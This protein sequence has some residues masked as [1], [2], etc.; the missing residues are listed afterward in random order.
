M[1]DMRYLGI[2]PFNASITSLTDQF[3]ALKLSGSLWRHK[4]KLCQKSDR[5]IIYTFLEMPCRETSV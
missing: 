3:H 5:L 2:Q 1:T 4:Q